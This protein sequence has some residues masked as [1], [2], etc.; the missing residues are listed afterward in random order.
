M[1]KNKIYL[2]I[3]AI[4]FLSVPWVFFESNQK[5]VFGLPIWAIYSLIITIVFA[6]VI[7]IIFEKKWDSFAG[8]DEDE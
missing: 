6:I 8:G 1:K 3:V 4:L 5:I 7:A 2:L